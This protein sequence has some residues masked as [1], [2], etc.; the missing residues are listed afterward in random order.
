MNKVD[1]TRYPY[2][3]VITE[4]GRRLGGKSRQAVNSL[5]KNPKNVEVRRLV[6]AIINERKQDIEAKAGGGGNR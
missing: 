3:G 5:L 4:A 6:D 2:K 1:L